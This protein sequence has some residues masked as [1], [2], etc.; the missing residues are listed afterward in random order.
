MLTKYKVMRGLF[1]RRVVRDLIWK[2]VAFFNKRRLGV[3]FEEQIKR[4]HESFVEFDEAHIASVVSELEASGALV[5]P[6]LP[7]EAIQYLLKYAEAH[8][9]FADRDQTKGF[10]LRDKAKAETSLKKEL[11]LAQYFNAEHDAMIAKIANDPY[12]LS[13]AAS[14]LK[15][16]PKLMSV[17]MWW[18]F[19]ANASEEDRAR[20]AH[21]FHFDL[22]DLKF[23]KFFFYLTDVDDQAGPHVFVKTSNRKIKYK[24]PMF[25]S[26]RFTDEEIVS[27]YGEEN[28]VKVLGPAGTCLIED[29]ITVHKG[30]T[31]VSSARLMLQFEYSI[32][33]YSEISCV[34]DRNAQK[35][36]V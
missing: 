25:R 10:Y 6:R 27:G 7:A 30:M 23:V 15:V 5:G 2:L 12:L 26:R 17:N 11:L 8:P 13:V 21:V 34:G 9:C 22:D 16:P 3:F 28:I 1:K 29:T 33:T 19:P 31:P 14:Y 24:S 20:H 4:K 36:F 35:I 18:T 32:N